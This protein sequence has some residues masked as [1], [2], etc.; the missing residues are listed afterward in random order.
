MLKLYMPG[1]SRLELKIFVLLD[2]LAVE[3]R[4]PGREVV[5]EE[6]GCP[7]RLLIAEKTWT[8]STTAPLDMVARIELRNPG[9]SILTA[10]GQT[11]MPCELMGCSVLHRSM[12]SWKAR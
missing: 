9:K 5:N 2:G 1:T 3:C 6:Y 11:S 12:L 8:K 7:F 4:D 10:D